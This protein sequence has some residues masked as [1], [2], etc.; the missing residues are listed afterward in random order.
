MESKGI[1]NTIKAMKSV[2]ELVKNYE[3]FYNTFSCKPD[4]Q[5][6]SCPKV[7][8]II[9]ED[10]SVRWNREEVKRLRNTYE[11][12]VKELNQYKNTI[13]N[14]YEK[15]IIKLLAK[16]NRIS[17]DESIIIWTYAWMRSH[18]EG[19]ESVVNTFNEIADLY[20]DLL[21]LKL[22]SQKFH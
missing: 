21:D 20:I 4:P 19:I 15:C 9:D 14:T 17:V 2:D 16:E 11:N 13:M 12:R 7:G 18:D 5:I 22:S 10:Q 8:T 6:Y 1:L 3:N